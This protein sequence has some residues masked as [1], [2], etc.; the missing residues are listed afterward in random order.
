[1]SVSVTS[2]KRTETRRGAREG[3]ADGRETGGRARGAEE[4]GKERCAD[5]TLNVLE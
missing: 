3:E 5:T 1:M 4:G 2:G